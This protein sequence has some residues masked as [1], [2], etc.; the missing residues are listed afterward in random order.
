[1]SFHTYH[2]HVKEPGFVAAL[3]VIA[4]VGGWVCLYDVRKGAFPPM[5]KVK[6]AGRWVVVYRPGKKFV[7]FHSREN[8]REAM[9]L[10]Q[11]C[12]EGHVKGVPVKLL[13]PKDQWLLTG[14]G[15]APVAVQVAGKKAAMEIEEAPPT[16]AKPSAKSK[17][18]VVRACDAAET[19]ESP[20]NG[21]PKDSPPPPSADSGNFHVEFRRLLNEEFTADKI[22]KEMKE[23]LT[24]ERTYVS[25][26]EIVTTPDWQVR[27]R[28]LRLVVEMSEGKAKERPE[29]KETKK[30][31]F[32]E[33][34]NLIK[35]SP[36]A[37]KALLR[38][39]ERAEKAEEE[40]Q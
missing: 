13:P 33:L 10:I 17:K 16:S 35:R 34:T 24:A 7:R 19:L 39:I 18:G 32:D 6:G 3:D 11:S 5:A 14:K 21:P 28:Y 36:A 25:A 1:M 9:R 8:A 31:T 15:V 4:P 37:R 30:V 26:G 2:P 27:E 23:G 20:P 12:K 29:V 38:E 40:Q 22:V